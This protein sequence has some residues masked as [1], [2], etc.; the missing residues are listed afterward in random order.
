MSNIC[1]AISDNHPNTTC[2]ALQYYATLS[3]LPLHYF[4]GFSLLGWVCPALIKKLS[5]H[6]ESCLSSFQHLGIYRVDKQNRTCVYLDRWYN[7]LE[8]CI[9]GS[10][11]GRKRGCN[12]SHC[13]FIWS[14]SITVMS[15]VAGAGSTGVYTLG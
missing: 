7:S 11:R 3:H 4:L 9:L 5:P 2:Q 15:G 13:Y 12:I 14:Q 6:L 1:V 8:T 10:K